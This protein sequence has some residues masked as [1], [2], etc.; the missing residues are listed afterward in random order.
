MPQAVYKLILTGH[1]SVQTTTKLVYS[2]PV[3]LPVSVQKLLNLAMVPS[4]L[5]CPNCPNYQNFIVLIQSKAFVYHILRYLFKNSRILTIFLSTST[6]SADIIQQS[7]NETT[8][9]RN[10]T[11]TTTTTISGKTKN[12]RKYY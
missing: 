10:A 8:K 3:S 2:Q 4:F 5:L 12:S 11:G 1:P 9:Q 7:N 6:N